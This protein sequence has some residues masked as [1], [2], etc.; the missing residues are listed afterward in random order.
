VSV[1]NP[2]FSELWRAD[3]EGRRYRTRPEKFARGEITVDDL[4]DEELARQQVRE[5]DGTFARMR[6]SIHINKIAE[7]QRALLARG[8]DV[9][10]AAFL[11]ATAT[12][13]EI[14]ADPNNPPQVRLQAAKMII[15]KVAPTAT[16]IEIKPH[17]P[18]LAFFEG[19]QESGGTELITGTVV[20]DPLEITR[21]D[22]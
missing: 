19:I 2:N 7:M 13:R 22:D 5:D 3:Q 21:G 20:P 14:C 10:K 8:N 1:P 4:D 17:D 18:V 9:F 12:M 6:P 15:D 11:E 16:I